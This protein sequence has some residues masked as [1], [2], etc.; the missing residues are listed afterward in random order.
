VQASEAAAAK[1]YQEQ[2]AAAHEASVQKHMDALHA[3]REAQAANSVVACE[4][5]DAT[6]RFKKWTNHFIAKH[7]RC[8]AFAGTEATAVL[9]A[10][11]RSDDKGKMIILDE[12]C[13]I[14]S[15][16]NHEGRQ[17]ALSISKSSL[18]EHIFAFQN[19]TL[20]ENWILML[21]VCVCLCVCVCV[22]V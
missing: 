16:N 15:I 14:R 22:C 20:R 9:R 12:R 4:R 2:A 8:C 1:K 5:Y 18:V 21:Q 13:R 3:L 11:Q 17:F 6:A 19:A 7:D 10:K